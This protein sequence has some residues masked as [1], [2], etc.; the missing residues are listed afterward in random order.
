MKSIAIVL[1][2]VGGHAASAI[3][4]GQARLVVR[5]DQ[6]RYTI[7]RHIYGQFAEHLGRDIYDGFWRKDAS[8]QWRLRDDVIEA[9]RR[10][11]VPNV[12]WPGGCFAD[13]YHWRDG[14]GAREARPTIVNTVWGG[15]TEDN[16]FGT[17]EYLELMDRLG[18]EPFIV[19]NVGSGSVQEMAQ[20]WEYVNFPGKSPMA[21][22]R[23]ANGREQPWN[24]R[25]WGVG[26]ES[27]GCGGN[28]RPDYYAS[29]YRQYVT[30]L[31]PYD[32]AAPFRIATGPIADNYDWTDVVMREAGR[33]IDGL[34]WHHY[35]W[36]HGS[37]TEFGEREWFAALQGAVRTESILVK[38]AEIMDRSDPEKRV[39]L[40]VGEWGMW[41]NVEP[42]TN[43]GFLYQQNT[44]RDALVAAVS[45]N[46][47]ARHAD[48]VRMANI[49]Q[50]VNVLQAMILTRGDQMILTPTY[51][52]FDLYSV[53]QDATLLPMTL[54]AGPYEF[55]GQ[56][57]PAVSAAA[58]RDK[59]GRVHLTLANLDPNRPRT[60]STDV[61]GMEVAGVSGRILTAGTMNAHNTFEQPNAVTTA[62]FTGAK[63]SG[64]TLTIDLPPKSVIML[65]LS[66]KPTLAEARTRGGSTAPARPG[67]ELRLDFRSSA[68]TI[69][70]SSGRGTGFTTRLPGA[71][72]NLRPND[73]N[74]HLDTVRARLTLT[75]TTADVNRQVNMPDLEAIGVKLASLGFTGSEDFSVSAR[76]IEIPDNSVLDLPD[77]LGVFVGTSTT[78]LV[79]AGFINLERYAPPGE[80]RFNKGFAVNTNGRDDSGP[81]FSGP[82]VGDT[83]TV[84][85]SR[86]AG[87]WRV[88]VNGA[89]RSPNGRQDGNGAPAPPA[90]LDGHSDLVVGV[91]A[92]DTN[93]KHKTLVLDEFAARVV[94]KR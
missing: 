65:E 74:L 3:A 37:A 48:R 49:A 81:N 73:V 11:K 75:T 55:E 91:F 53:H 34:D 58:S 66:P 9:L 42:G 17:H 56:G 82:D 8:G 45:L 41:H 43:P 38:H 94:P 64:R 51:H 44:L 31:R 29:L 83:M 4:Q 54:D 57:I 79:R 86:T 62:P 32:G 20:W 19:G 6:G 39:W 22:L 12:R 1:L 89:D 36:S 72:G 69:K 90:F 85:I 60:V 28:M 70:D 63:L 46:I 93:G 26:N 47:F 14:I 78:S 77:Q 18:A 15:V 61:Q 27:W 2:L 24:V 84:E 23:R 80:K 10:I 21:D 67:K 5:A 88:L 50:A 68:G 25:L 40:I 71:G 92:L 35:I 30:F 59:Q 7:S 33:F 52:V 13:Y 87:I 16:S 76:F